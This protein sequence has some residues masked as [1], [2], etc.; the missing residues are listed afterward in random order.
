LFVQRTLIIDH[1]GIFDTPC[2]E[3]NH[4]LCIANSTNLS[5]MPSTAA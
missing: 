5:L 4:T 2:I 1:S 3:K